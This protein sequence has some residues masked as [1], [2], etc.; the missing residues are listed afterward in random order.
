MFKGKKGIF[1]NYIDHWNKIKEQAT[2]N[3]NNGLRT[4]AKLM[5]P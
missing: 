4:I 2:I 1:D 5:K 3:K